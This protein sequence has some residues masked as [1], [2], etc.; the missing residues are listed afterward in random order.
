MYRSHLSYAFL[1]GVI[2]SI[3]LLR[4]WELP[5]YPLWLW[6][7]LG[8]VCFASIPLKKFLLTALMIGASLGILRMQQ[9]THVTSANT[10]D[11]YADGRT[12]DAKA[13]VVKTPERRLTG[14]RY[15]LQIQELDDHVP[16]GLVRSDDARTDV[17]FLQGDT[18]HIRGKLSGIEDDEDVLYSR[19]AAIK[20][21]YATLDHPSLTLVQ[22]APSANPL[23][24]L[25]NQK[26][27]LETHI[28]TLFPE[29]YAA[30]LTG[31]LT[32]SQGRIPPSLGDAFS[33]TGLTHMLAIS[34]FNITLILSLVQGA[35][36]FLPKKWRLVPAGIAVVIFTL[37]VGAS[38]SAVRACVMGC[39]GLLAMQS[40]R[41][42]TTRL[43]IF[44]AM[45]GMLLL[46]PQSFWDDAGFQLSFLAV[47]GL[48]EFSEVM[49]RLTNHVTEKGGLREQ[50]HATLTAQLLTTP[51]IAYVFG[52]M[53]LI[54]PLAN[55][56]TAP[57]VPLAMLFGA[58]TLAADFLRL[59]L[60]PT[61]LQSIAMMP[62][63]WLTHV[64]MFLSKIP[65][66]SIEI[67]K[68]HGLLLCISMI[69]VLARRSWKGFQIKR[70]E[71]NEGIGTGIP[72]PF[73]TEKG[74]G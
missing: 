24:F 23:A 34:G 57:L 69:A 19:I 58:L 72:S 29:P 32:G 4:F 37:F 20:G 25:G 47:I 74:E 61:L 2:G 54:A 40:Q 30:L 59:P 45:A 66:A 13:I 22:T 3:A 46:K 7:L 21:V 15:L 44:W 73:S 64:P 27:R 56:L 33:T 14:T 12:L 17:R 41:K 5:M 9:T 43:I 42:K 8:L 10:I 31:L 68:N 67:S 11:F 50:L 18:L 49:L 70:N 26:L 52:R 65:F 36:F 63:W 39:L 1:A 60:L 38:A 71:G 6:L 28:S 51:W 62:L 53:S 48:S 55:V 35:L 16:L